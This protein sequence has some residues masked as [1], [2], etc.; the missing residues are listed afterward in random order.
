MV[1]EP[2]GGWERSIACCRW[3]ARSL[4]SLIYGHC[5]SLVFAEVEYLN[6]YIVRLAVESGASAPLAHTLALL[7]QA[8]GDSVRDLWQV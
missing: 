6:G 8:R 4:T 7:V 3:L 2:T 5:C 1:R